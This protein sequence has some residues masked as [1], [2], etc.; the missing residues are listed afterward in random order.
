MN[1]VFVCSHAVEM[2][3]LVQP[4]NF[5]NVRKVHLREGKQSESGKH[6]RMWIQSRY[7]ISSSAS[8]FLN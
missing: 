7:V 8:S 2:C 3:Y 5:L 6:N 1:S 4:L